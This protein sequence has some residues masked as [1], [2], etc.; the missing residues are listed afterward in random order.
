MKMPEQTTRALSPQEV[1]D[2]VGDLDDAKIAAILATDAS[3][4]ELEEAAAWAAG[5]ATSWAIWS[6]RSKAWSPGC[7]RS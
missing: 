6:G 2:I 7:T 1:R 3:P 4:E 5:R